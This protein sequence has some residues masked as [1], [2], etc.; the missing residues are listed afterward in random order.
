MKIAYVLHARFPSPK[1]YGKQVAEVCAAMAANKHAV[2]LLLPTMHNTF[3]ENPF[4]FYGL[5]KKAF[6]IAHVAHTD[7]TKKRWIPGKL[8]LLAGMFFYR[9]ALKRYLK[10]HPFD[11][12]YCRSE[13]VLPALL[14]TRIPVVIEL[15]ALPRRNKKGFVKMLKRC[16][17]VVCLTE[18]MKK[19]LVTWKV[20]ASHI[21]V[22]PDGVDTERF[23]D[24]PEPEECKEKWAL[25]PDVPVVGYVGTLVTQETIDKGVGDLVEAFDILRK[26][27]TEFFGWIVGGPAPRA[28]AL[29]KT[30]REKKL[31]NLVHV[32]GPI[33]PAEVPSALQGCDVLVYPA[34]KS[35]HAY[36]LRD[37]SPL[38][39][40]EYLAAGKPVV[41][42]DLPPLRDIV[43]GEDVTLAAPGD[44]AGLAGAISSVLG[45]LEA[46]VEKAEKAKA[47]AL[48]HDWAK[49]MARIVKA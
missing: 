6:T 48:K 3:A 41:C 49:R 34:P 28:E 33:P 7:A 12:F 23:A 35:T 1:A 26:R 11:L 18:G 42:A 40:F 37:T 22:E 46:A 15:H 8:H 45:D 44:P 30:L 38:K 27:G 32:Q 10:K 4:T 47:I 31:H 2:T 36:F 25:P 9:R 14:K 39:L 29:K 21:M 20:P 13:L 17:K 19:E 5:P 16:K 43:S 24:L